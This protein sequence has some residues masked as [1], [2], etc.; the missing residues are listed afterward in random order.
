MHTQ[1]LDLC[2]TLPKRLVWLWNKLERPER[3]LVP[4]PGEG[5]ERKRREGE[6]LAVLSPLLSPYT[7]LSHPSQVNTAK[8]PECQLT[9]HKHSTPVQ[10]PSPL[11]LLNSCVIAGPLPGVAVA[12]VEWG[13]GERKRGQLILATNLWHGKMS[14]E[15]GSGWVR[16]ADAILSHRGF[17]FSLLTLSDREI[18]MPWESKS[19]RAQCQ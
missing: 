11:S 8:Y 12:W 5:E 4:W 15:S 19:R 16:Q 6:L 1:A 2:F 3:N 7:P 18:W 10:C 17:W 14:K 9:A 13:G